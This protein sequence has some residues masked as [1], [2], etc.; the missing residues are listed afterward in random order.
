MVEVH[1]YT[2]GGSRGN[3]GPAAS[4]FLA[5][6]KEGGRERAIRKMARRIGKATN[7]QA[8][9]RAV[10]MALEWAISRGFRRVVLHSDSELVVKQI[11]GEYAV[12]SHSLRDL[13]LRVKEL[14]SGLEWKAMNHPREEPHISQ[15]DELVN[16][17][18]DAR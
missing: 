1:I 17:A 11:T 10:I 13:N 3:P 18:L 15:C 6:V 9:Y 7:N 12:R 16:K 5:I 14:L 2:D 4:A 8:E